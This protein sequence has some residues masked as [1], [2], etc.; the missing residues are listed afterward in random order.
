MRSE[1]KEKKRGTIFIGLS[2]LQATKS[3]Y[4]YRER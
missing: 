3:F 4:N 2:L 1:N